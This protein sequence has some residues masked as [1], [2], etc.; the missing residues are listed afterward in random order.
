MRFRRLGSLGFA[1]ALVVASGLT[2]GGGSTRAQDTEAA[3]PAH[4]HT[5][6]CEAPG[7]VVIPLSDIGSDYLVDGEATAGDAVGLG[8]AVETQGS[9]TT[10]DAP[11]SDILDG[12]HVLMVHLSAEEI[13]TYVACGDVGGTMMGDSD[14]VFGIKPLNDSGLS[15]IATLHDNGDD[16]TT[17]SVYLTKEAED[18]G[19]DTGDAAAS[20]A[21]SP[22]AGDTG[23]DAAAAV[24]VDIHNFT[25]GGGPDAPLEIAVGTTVTWTNTDGVPHTV[26]SSDGTLK[27]DALQTGDSFSYTFDKAGTFDYH[28]EFHAQMKASVV[29]S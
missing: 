4:I 3:H 6:T 5:G 8:S 23:A 21:A 11:L 15:G 22:A 29:V 14:L 17:I 1:G 13:G 19:D 25:Y 27:S 26:T 18:G 24:Q 2:I 28:C 10:A 20:P 7:E 12:D 9:V 16:T